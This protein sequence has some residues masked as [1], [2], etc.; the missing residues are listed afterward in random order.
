MLLYIRNLTTLFPGNEKP[1]LQHRPPHTL[2]GKGLKKSKEWYKEI[3][4]TA[5]AH[6]YF[7]FFGARMR[8]RN[9][10][11]ANPNRWDSWR[12]GYHDFSTVLR[13]NQFFQGRSF[14]HKK[15]SHGSSAQPEDGLGR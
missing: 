12:T 11:K 5:N 8:A 1:D 15:Y 9:K 3:T 13:T 4:V 7:P 6:G 10:E 2:S 14:Q